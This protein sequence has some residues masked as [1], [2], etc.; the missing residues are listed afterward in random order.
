MPNSWNAKVPD[1]DAGTCKGRPNQLF[2]GE[3]SAIYR[4]VY[5]PMDPQRSGYHLFSTGLTWFNQY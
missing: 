3:T 1:G 4:V 5:G 2:D